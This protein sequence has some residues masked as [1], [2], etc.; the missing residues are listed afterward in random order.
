M[1]TL[2]PL[3]PAAPIRLIVGLGNPGPEYERTRHNAGFWFAD[4]A[5]RSVGARF[6]AARKFFGETARGAPPHADLWLLKPHTYMN[7]SGLAVAALANFYQIAPHEILVV[8]DELDLPPGAARLKRGGGHA[9]HNGLRDI[10]SKLGSP[11]TW[12][13]RLGIGHPR[14]LQLEQDVADFVLHPPRRDEQLAIEAALDRA[15][16]VL[17]LIVRGGFERA[18]MQLHAVPPPAASS[19]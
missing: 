2:A 16:A 10:Q 13:L 7:R 14:T 1:A 17:P 3:A 9:G 6:A 8:H 19:P 5:A 4:A 18:M 12:R 11:D 15:L